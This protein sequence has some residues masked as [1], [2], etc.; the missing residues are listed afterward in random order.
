M[1][2]RLLAV[3]AWLW[4][5]GGAPAAAQPWNRDTAYSEREAALRRA[6]AARP[7]DVNALVDLAAFYLK[8]LAPRTVAAADGRVRTFLVP[9]RNEIIPGGI[10]LTY[11][12]PWVFRGDTSAAWPLLSKAIAIDPRNARAARELAMYYRMRGDLDRMKPYMEAALQ[13]NPL[14]LDMCRL[15]LDH[16]TGLA[17]V[18]NDQ[19]VDLRTPRVHE[20]DRPDGRYRVT[21]HPSEADYARARQLDAQAQTVRREAVIPLNRLA[22]ALRDDPTRPSTPA[23]QAKWR[24]A[25]AVYFQW[26]GE[27]EKAAGTAAAGLREDP[28]DL[29]SLDYLIDI[30]RGTRTTARHLEYKAILDRWTGADSKPI[31]PAAAPRGSRR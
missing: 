18:L 15:Y 2:H 23:K 10:K 25:T 26:I 6:I 22:G 7:N 17:R 1:G 28:T 16:R 19:A 8:P 27:L 31:V 14:D 20:E 9:L 4:L 29:D 30:L 21:T 5:V 3:A 13:Q 24:L 12:V 11:A